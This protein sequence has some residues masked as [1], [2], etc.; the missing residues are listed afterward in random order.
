MARKRADYQAPARRAR[1][2]R[3]VVPTATAPAA[4][5]S[6]F[7]PGT[8]KKVLVG[9][10]LGAVALS[11]L[12]YVVLD[13]QR[14]ERRLATALLAGGACETDRRTDPTRGDGHVSDPVFRVDPP[15]GGDHT[16]DVAKAGVYA[17]DDVPDDGRL[18]HALEHGYVVLWHR[19]GTSTSALE[20]LA[21]DHEGDVIVAERAS[22]PV[23][24]AATAWERR[25]LCTDL[26]ANALELFVDAYV[27]DGPEDVRRG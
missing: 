10:V 4:R 12:A 11:S 23:P 14:D 3:P 2:K 21:E 19:P 25:L 1:E 24:V 15:A 6:A 16:E 13:R 27:G 5:E 18:V 9:G 22:L 26:D 7:P 20:Q 17:G 8:L